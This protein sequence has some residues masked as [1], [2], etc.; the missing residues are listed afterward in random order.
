MTT[1]SK[2]FHYFLKLHR[3]S[4]QTILYETN[5]LITKRS[6]F[7]QN[8][9]MLWNIAHCMNHDVSIAKEKGKKKEKKR[10]LS[11]QFI[12]GEKYITTYS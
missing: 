4:N 5:G 3:R 7:L 12:K 6:F 10:R 8:S 2:N 1:S 11:Q 9:Y